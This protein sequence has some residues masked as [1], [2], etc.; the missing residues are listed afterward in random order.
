MRTLVV[1]LLALF[2][3]SVAVAQPRVVQRRHDTRG[4]HVGAI[5]IDGDYVAERVRG[6]VTRRLSDLA[7]CRD[8]AM[9]H[10]PSL[11][12]T[13][14]VRFTLGTRGEVLA[15][16]I[17]ENE[18]GDPDLAPCV[19]MQ[20]Q[21]WHFPAPRRGDAIVVTVPFEFRASEVSP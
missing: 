13:L 14:S 4:M 8:A 16:S 5:S 3:S 6:G 19:L 18:T 20:M 7:T 11:D 1:V 9:V 10:V 12:A 21:S 2:G 17:V 15:P